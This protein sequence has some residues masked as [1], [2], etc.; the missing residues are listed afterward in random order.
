[1]TKRKGYHHGNLR[2]GLVAAGLELVRK[3]GASALTTR[4]CAQW[5][6]VSSSAVFRHFRDR[7]ALLRAVAAEGFAMLARTTAIDDPGLT[8]QDR[9]LAIGGAYLRFAI[10]EPNLFRLMYGGDALDTTDPNPDPDLEAAADPLLAQTA[11][12]AGAEGDTSDP[13]TLLAWS[14]VHGLAMLTLDNQLEGLVPSDPRERAERLEAIL[15]H[16]LPLFA[17]VGRSER[18][19]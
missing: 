19:G 9:L 6:G 13:R 11:L 10:N 4:A 5:N 16:A 15:V 12:A 18:R 1:M 8:R 14:I 2:A 17:D 3:D 7:P